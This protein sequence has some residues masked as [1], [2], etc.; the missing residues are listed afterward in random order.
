MS[1]SNFGVSVIGALSPIGYRSGSATRWSARS[2][3]ETQ[4]PERPE[5]LPSQRMQ[6][7]DSIVREAQD[8]F[9]ANQVEMHNPHDSARL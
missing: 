6:R 5:A 1:M 7:I 8:I 4:S 9:V 3:G 2:H